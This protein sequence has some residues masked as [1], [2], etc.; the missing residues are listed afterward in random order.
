MHWTAATSLADRL[1]WL[2]D[3]LC[4]TI[5]AEAQARGVEPALAWAIWNRVRLLGARLIALAERRPGGRVRVVTA[6]RRA[7]GPRAPRSP[8]AQCRAAHGLPGGF[9][10][11]PRLL[12]KTADYAGVLRYLLS[13]PELAA[14]LEQAPQSARALRP[15]CH[16]LGVTAP[17]MRRT[18]AGDGAAQEGPAPHLA[19]GSGPE[20]GPPPPRAEEVVAPVAEGAAAAEA[21]PQAPPPQAPAYGMSTNPYP[22]E[23][24]RRPGGLYWD[25]KGLR[26][27]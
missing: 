24:Y 3:G 18:P 9:G 23:Y 15:L 12:P 14:L 16:L 11:L 26:W 10:W 21:A 4:R 13:D 19:P 20:A 27:S 17:E 8:R 2:I 1:T 6:A 25:G 7:A 5:G 22:D